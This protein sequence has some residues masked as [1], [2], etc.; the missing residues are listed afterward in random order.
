MISV[1]TFRLLLIVFTLF[2]G[3]NYT[4]C[5]AYEPIYLS[6]H[7]DNVYQIVLNGEES[8]LASASEDNLAI[9]WDLK[10]M[11]ILQKLEHEKP[12]YDLAFLENGK[13]LVTIGGDQFVRIW[14]VQTGKL[15]QSIDA[16]FFPLY[17][18]A[19]SSDES[20]LAVGGGEKKPTI[21]IYEFAKKKW[22]ASDSSQKKTIYGLAFHPL[23]TLI[24]SSS[25]DHSI[26]LWDLK[27]NKKN[28]L[29]GHKSDVYRC[30]FSSD[31]KMLYS[32][33][34]DKT[35]KIWSIE[36]KSIL[37]SLAVSKDPLYSVC[38]FSNDQTIFVAG[39]EGIIHRI[40]LQKVL[41][42]TKNNESNKFPSKEGIHNEIEFNKPIF[43]VTYNKKSKQLFTGLG[44]GKIRIDPFDPK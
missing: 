27:T 10:T 9:V 12:I 38:L 42:K 30:K 39:D 3:I 36:K 31:G 13:K 19:I 4:V 37:A 7:K 11:S 41:K 14:S 23:N 16:N 33:S 25:S 17:S 26:Q 5:L 1:Q 21:S 43:S 24:A 20:L 22:I 8:L 2:D 15:F 34:Q 40:H 28:L 35:T 32:V 6:G 29:L 44:N 18:L